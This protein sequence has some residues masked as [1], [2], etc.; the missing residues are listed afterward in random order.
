MSKK[1]YYEY[2]PGK[3]TI[4]AWKITEAVKKFFAEKK[5]TDSSAKPDVNTDSLPT[6][7]PESKRDR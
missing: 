5:K 7:K 3:G 1:K 2:P 6:D 4:P